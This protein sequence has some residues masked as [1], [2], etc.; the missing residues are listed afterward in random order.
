MQNVQAMQATS[1]FYQQPQQTLQQTGFFQAQ[2]T[3]TG[4]QVILCFM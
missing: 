4:L 3:S 2:Q 1:S